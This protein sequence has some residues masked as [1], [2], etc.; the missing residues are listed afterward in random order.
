MSVTR[1]QVYEKAR[2]LALQLLC[3]LHPKCADPETEE[4]LK[5]E[6]S[7]WVDG[8]DDECIEEFCALLSSPANNTFQ[9]GLKA[10]QGWKTSGFETA[11]PSICFSPLLTT[12]LTTIATA[13][14]PF[15]LF[16][17]QVLTNCLLYQRHP[18]PLASVIATTIADLKFAARPLILLRQYAQSLIARGDWDAEKRVSLLAS[19][20]KTL[21]SSDFLQCM[22]MISLQDGIDLDL[23]LARFSLGDVTTAV[24]QCLH[25]L[26]LAK[27]INS[28]FAKRSFSQLRTF[29]PLLAQ[30]SAMFRL[31]KPRC[32]NKE[33]ELILVTL[34]FVRA[35]VSESKTAI[36]VS[37][38]NTPF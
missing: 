22:S 36:S 35:K 21:F 33:F 16:I 1:K 4:C 26:A 25:V 13:S 37:Y 34:F 18:L 24:R 12:S 2:S 3:C 30:V 32:G 20:I 23:S 7:L 6:T 9:H 27:D 28:T 15:R 11:L 31:V 38:L 5:H 14:E 10:F 29:I 8:L 19:L 17:C